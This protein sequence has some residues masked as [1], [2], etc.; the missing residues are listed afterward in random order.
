MANTYGVMYL[1][2]PRKGK[3]VYYS[4]TEE[5]QLGKGNIVRDGTDATVIACGIKVVMHWK[6]LRIWQKKISRCVW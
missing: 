2:F 1:R 4:G 3:T 5:F 6:Q